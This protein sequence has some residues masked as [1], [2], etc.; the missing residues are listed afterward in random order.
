MGKRVI[1]AACVLI[2]AFVIT[3]V[4]YIQQTNQYKDWISTQGVLYNHEEVSSRH[5]RFGSSSSY[6]L[7]YTYEVNGIEYA[8]VDSYSGELPDHYH[9]GDTVKVMY[10]AN[11]PSSSLHEKPKINLITRVPMMWAIPIALMMLLPLKK[12]KENNKIFGQ[13][14]EKEE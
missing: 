3:I 6:R 9:I 14:W 8:G 1:R 5:S 4:L 11:E 2:I 13:K 12:R 7:Y 10:D